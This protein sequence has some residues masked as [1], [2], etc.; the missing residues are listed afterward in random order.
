MVF[1]FCIEN[2]T[3][4]EYICILEQTN[5]DA[6]VSNFYGNLAITKKKLE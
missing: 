2:Y 6:I 3:K 5:L 4:S 1:Q